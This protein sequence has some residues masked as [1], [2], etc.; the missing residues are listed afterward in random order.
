MRVVVPGTRDDQDRVVE[1]ICS[2]FE[3]A[4]V[5]DRRAKPSHGY[6]AVHVVVQVQDYSVEVQVRT[7]LQD[8]WAQLVERLGDSW[9][10]RSAT[11][12]HP[13][14]PARC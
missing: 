8:R 5:V 2:Q 1:Q 10:G 14:S 6:R 13:T 11:V 12:N 9:A 3:R 4:K 7:E